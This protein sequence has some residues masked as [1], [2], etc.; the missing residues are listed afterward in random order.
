M[1]AKTAGTVSSL[2]A[3]ELLCAAIWYSL[4]TK[5]IPGRGELF[6]HAYAI[7]CKYVLAFEYQTHALL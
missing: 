3:E 4:E 2:L 5:C 7:L 6:E 1:R